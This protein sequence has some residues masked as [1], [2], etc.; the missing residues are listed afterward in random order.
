MTAA[1]FGRSEGVRL[2]FLFVA[3][4]AVLGCGEPAGDNGTARTIEESGRLDRLAVTVG[5]RSTELPLVRNCADSVGAESGV[6]APKCKPVT[7]EERRPRIGA[8]GGDLVTVTTGEGAATVTL[9]GVRTAHGRPVYVD[10]DPLDE[11]RQRWRVRLPSPLTARKLLLSV[12]PLRTD[13]GSLGF[14]FRLDRT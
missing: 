4:L 13:S 8:R 3:C 2:P 11:A 9:I 1:P 6:V 12:S 7:D 14:G 10:A 5:N